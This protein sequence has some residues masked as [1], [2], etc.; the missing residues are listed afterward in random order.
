MSTIS[1]AGPELTEVEGLSQGV[2]EELQLRRGQSRGLEFQTS[3]VEVTGTV[4]SDSPTDS[5]SVPNPSNNTTAS[6][7]QSQTP[8]VSPQAPGAA[9]QA[10]PP[11][12]SPLAQQ[13]V[14]PQGLSPFGEAPEGLTPFGEAP[15]GLAPQ[16]VV[17]KGLHPHGLSPKGN[18]PMG[19][20][21][22]GLTLVDA[23][24]GAGRAD[25]NSTVGY[26]V[27]E[28]NLSRFRLEEKTSDGFIIGEYGVVDHTTGDVNGVRYTADSTADPRL[29]YESLMKFLEL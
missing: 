19:N 27:E 24:V 26:V 20:S 6:N 18:S 10:L 15:E 13:G 9:T 23:T 4:A 11:V 22:A 12:G 25:A 14:A 1:T 16:G 28:H 8:G 3:V 7:I 2:V 5:A 17:P 21:T 29:I